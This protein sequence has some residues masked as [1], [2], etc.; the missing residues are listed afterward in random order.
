MLPGRRET[1]GTELA[2]PKCVKP[3][4][5]AAPLLD[6]KARRNGCPSSRESACSSTH[7]CPAAEQ[8][9]CQL[10]HVGEHSVCTFDGV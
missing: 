3:G 5:P 4:D 2:A 8:P 1:V 7:G 9:T 6:V 10:M